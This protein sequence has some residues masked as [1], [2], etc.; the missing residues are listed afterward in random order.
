MAAS[1]LSTDGGAGLEPVQAWRIHIGA[2]K[3]ATTHFQNTL[4]DHRT[5]LLTRGIDYVPVCKVRPLGAA[6]LRRRN[7]RL[8]VGGRPM[9]RAFLQAVAPL[10]RGPGIVAISEENGLGHANEAVSATP[11][12]TLGWR[13]RGLRALTADAKLTLF[14]SIRSFDRLIPSAYAEGLRHGP[15]RMPFAAAKDA[16]LAK[17]PSWLGMIARMR[18]IAPG[19]ELR[20]WRYEDYADHWREII[21][22]FCGCDPGPLPVLPRPSRT[23]TPCAEAVA[24]AEALDPGLPLETWRRRVEA[25]YAEAPTNQAST[26]YAPLTAAEAAVLRARYDEDVETLGRTSPGTLLCF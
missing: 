14:L 9:A 6:W 18:R 13:L 26:G 12:P 1:L 10:R 21:S 5:A 4:D 15:P 20:V 8:W 23:M 2:H 25:I 11:Y 17:P 22:A 3:T 7:W 16:F 24:R 19:L